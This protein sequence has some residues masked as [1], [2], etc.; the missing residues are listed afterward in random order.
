MGGESHQLA[1]QGVARS[2]PPAFA[3]HQKAFYG[4]TK[5]VHSPLPPVAAVVTD[6]ASLGTR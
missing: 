6:A 2:W 3:P 5:R 4:Q 1:R